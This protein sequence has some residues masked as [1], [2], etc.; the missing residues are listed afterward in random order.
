MPTALPHKYRDDIDENG[1]TVI[2]GFLTPEEVTLYREASA[3]LV[4]Y[5]RAGNWNDVRIRGKQFP[6]WP[7]DF[8]PDIWGVSGLLHPDLK[9]LSYPFHEAYASDKMLAVVS[10]ILQVPQEKISMELFNM[11]INPLTDFDLEWHRDDIRPDVTPEEEA[12][13]LDCAF[14]GCQ[15]NLALYEDD[16]LI[17][18]PKSHKRIRTAEE[19]K[20]T[21][22]ETKKLPISSQMAVALQPGDLAFYNP[23]IVHRGVYNSKKPRLTLHGCYGHTDNGGR[24]A[25]LVLQHGV[26]SWLDRLEPRNAN[27]AQLKVGLEKLAE[28]NKNK[29][30]G[31]SLEG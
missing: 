30:I 16:C 25:R 9:E 28:E 2:R 3:K 8:N 21:T 11:L 1:F 14:A 6:P 24:R 17:V 31:F 12:E 26:A 19:R 5:A 10:D 22:D 7:K 18:I 29:D 13:Q 23:N 4:D 27:L 15:F 20:K